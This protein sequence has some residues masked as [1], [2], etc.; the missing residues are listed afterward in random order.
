[1]SI[2]KPDIKA[3]ILTAI[4]RSESVGLMEPLRIGESAPQRSALTDLAVDLAARAAGFRRS[5]PDGVR[6]ALADLVRARS[7]P[8]EGKHSSL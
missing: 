8:G 2:H 6:G 7:Y 1:M 3:D 5:L 4:D